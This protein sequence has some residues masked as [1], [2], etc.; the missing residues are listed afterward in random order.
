MPQKEPGYHANEVIRCYTLQEIE[1]LLKKANFEDIIHISRKQI[2]D[3]NVLLEPWDTRDI[4]VGTK[5]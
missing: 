3:P 5:L 2:D 4:V 1:R